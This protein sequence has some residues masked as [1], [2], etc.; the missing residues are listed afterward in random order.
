MEA[1][2]DTRTKRQI[3]TVPKSRGVVPDDVIIDLP[4]RNHLEGC[5]MEER[6]LDF[7]TTRPVPE[8][9]TPVGEEV[10]VV[11]C[12]ECGGEKVTPLSQVEREDPDDNDE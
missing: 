2:V 12:T 7:W 4:E 9:G 1:S 5:P 3:A 6:R 10:V 11:R 8:K